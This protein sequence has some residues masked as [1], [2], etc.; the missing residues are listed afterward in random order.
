M[1]PSMDTE[2]ISPSQ[3][4]IIARTKP[5][6][7]LSCGGRLS[8]VIVVDSAGLPEVLFLRNCSSKPLSEEN[9]PVDSISTLPE[10]SK[11]TPLSKSSSNIS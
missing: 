2:K 3:E 6:E 9:R 4:S 10:N 11:L 8:M 1:T 5:K 7:I